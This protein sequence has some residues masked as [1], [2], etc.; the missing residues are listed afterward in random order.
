DLLRVTTIASLLPLAIGSLPSEIL[1][2]LVAHVVDPREFNTPI[3]LPTVSRSD[4]LFLKDTWRGP[5]WVNTAWMVLF[6][7]GL[8]GKDDITGDFAYRLVKGVYETRAKCG[9]FYEFY[10]PDG[11]TLAGLHRKQGNL[12]KKITLGD[13]PIH[14]FC[15]WTALVNTI[16]LE[17][18]LGYA[19]NAGVVIL[20]PHLPA[21]WR[22]VT[23][24][25]TIPQFGEEI[26]MHVPSSG[27]LTA[28][29]LVSSR[30]VPET[31][32]VFYFQGQNH[33]ELRRIN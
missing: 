17:N 1:N 14:N 28:K 18:I 25:V 31:G 24:Y 11:P 29:I 30:N 5:V 12:G 32:S 15:G 13:K 7:L 20:K 16:L 9:S 3:P 21:H 33:T 2:S 23:F 10:D 22:N 19:R 6:G 4:P 27:E 8:N 26:E